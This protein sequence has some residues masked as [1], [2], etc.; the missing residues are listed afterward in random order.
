MV[1]SLA[2]QSPQLNVRL[3]VVDDLR[4]ALGS[5]GHSYMVTPNIDNLARHSVLFQ[6]AFVQV[7]LR[8]RVDVCMI[9]HMT[10]VNA[11]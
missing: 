9:F 7:S 5:Y 10:F 11:I 1:I 8:M 2:T 3:I 4:P 6:N